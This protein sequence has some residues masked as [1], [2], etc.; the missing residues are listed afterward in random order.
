MIVEST[1]QRPVAAGH[2]EHSHRLTFLLEPAF[3]AL[4]HVRGCAFCSHALTLSRGALIIA[5]QLAISGFVP[6]AMA[7]ESVA[8]PAAAFGEWSADGGDN[9]WSN[10]VRRAISSHFT[11]LANRRTRERPIAKAT[12]QGLGALPSYQTEDVLSVSPLRP[13]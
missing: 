10:A 7:G 6:T 8:L 4:H 1:Q 5:Q 3:D 2:L 9:D 11:P 12:Y 13:P